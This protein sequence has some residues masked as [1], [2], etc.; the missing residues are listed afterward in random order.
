MLKKFEELLVIAIAL[1]LTG[2]AEWQDNKLVKQQAVTFENEIAYRQRRE[3]ELENK[4]KKANE[5]ISKLE[6]QL[7][8]QKE[9]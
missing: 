7:E 6:Q 1:F 5:T 9:N 8:C 4:L 3:I 2:C